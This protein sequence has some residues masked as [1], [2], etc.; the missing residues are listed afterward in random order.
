MFV[1][2]RRLDVGLWQR[3]RLGVLATAFQR[4]TIP[5]SREYFGRRRLD[6]AIGVRVGGI[7]IAPDVHICCDSREP[8]F[9]SRICALRYAFPQLRG[10]AIPERCSRAQDQPRCPR[11]VIPSA[12]IA[13]VAV[14]P[15]CLNSGGQKRLNAATIDRCRHISI[16]LY[17]LYE[18]R[19]YE[20]AEKE[21]GQALLAQPNDARSLAL[22]ALCLL[23]Q[24][25]FTEATQ[26][27]QEAVGNAPDE[28]F[29]HHTLGRVWFQ[30]NYLDQ[31]EQ[32]T[33]AALA[34]DPHV[35]GYYVTQA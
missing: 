1:S 31:A 3:S 30:R 5:V 18:Q 29:S 16:A 24:E 17:L 34:I 11:K 35:T 22:L 27:A 32:E 20:L 8:G 23:E 9:A 7:A 28:S 19:R 12:V 14:I 26:R 15:L 10:F 6:C 2:N 25:K 21:I 4:A 13:S 33:Q